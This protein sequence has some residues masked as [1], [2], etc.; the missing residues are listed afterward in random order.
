MKFDIVNR[1]VNYLLLTMVVCFYS[2]LIP[3]GTL[4]L[5]VSFFLQFWIDKMNL[6][7]RSSH[8]RNFSFHLTRKILKIFEANILVFAL[9]T[10]VWGFYVHNN[11][12]NI[13]NLIGLLIAALYFWFLVGVGVRT[14]RSIFGS[15][16]S[17]Q[18][19]IYDDC[20]VA[21]KFE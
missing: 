12:F 1:Y 6:F 21:G 18:S 5:F 9:G 15:Y 8:P 7:K 3:V 11:T 20:V 10:L 14:E 4:V 17:S 2:Y 16:E 19:L 13:L